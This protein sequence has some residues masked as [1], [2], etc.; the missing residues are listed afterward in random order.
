MVKIKTVKDNFYK[1]ERACKVLDGKRVNVFADGEHAALAAIHEYGLDIEVTDNMRGYLHSQGLHLNPNTK[2]IHIPERAFL[3]GGFDANHKRILD[4]AENFEK[5]VFG[6]VLEPEDL[7]AHVGYLLKWAI[8]EYAT[9]LKDPPNH[10]FTVKQK[11]TDQTL[12]ETGSM[13]GELKKESSP[14]L[15]D[16]DEDGIIYEIV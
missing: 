5:L 14:K 9:E 2:Y 16:D 8:K 6:G 7:L 3:R 10:P 4:E 1:M 12:W 15:V 13:I 11:D